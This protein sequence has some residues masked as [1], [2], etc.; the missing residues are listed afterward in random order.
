PGGW[1]D[2]QFI[3]TIRTGTNPQGKLLDPEFMPW[4][5]FTQMTDDEL[6]AI[7]LYL[8]SLPAREIEE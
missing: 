6:Q 4:P 7:W 2:A 1:T 8:Q 3:N 5:R